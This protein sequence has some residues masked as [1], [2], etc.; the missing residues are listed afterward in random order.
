ML[1]VNEELE[2]KSI[3]LAFSIED[4]ENIQNSLDSPLLVV[5]ARGYFRHINEDARRLYLGE[6]FRL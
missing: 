4:L 2:H 3:E 5:D 1:T 6:D